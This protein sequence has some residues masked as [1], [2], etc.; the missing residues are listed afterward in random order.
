MVVNH[1]KIEFIVETLSKLEYAVRKAAQLQRDY[2]DAQISIR[3]E[4]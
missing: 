2:P 4:M 3:V 1:I